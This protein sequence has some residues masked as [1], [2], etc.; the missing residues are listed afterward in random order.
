MEEW[1]MT[2]TKTAVERL[3]RTLKEKNETWQLIYPVAGILL[4]V[5]TG[6]AAYQ[7]DTIAVVFASGACLATYAIERDREHTR[8]S[9]PDAGGGTA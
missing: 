8:E 7:G 9:D 4:L 2:R 1:R 3:N 5:S 6:V